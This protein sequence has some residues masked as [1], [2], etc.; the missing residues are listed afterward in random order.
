M[1]VLRICDRQSLSILAAARPAGVVV[2][3]PFDDHDPATLL[4]IIRDMHPD[5]PV[6]FLREAGPASEAVRLLRLGACEY[7]DVVADAEAWRPAAPKRP[8]SADTWRRFLIGESPA[9][10]PVF[11]TIRLLGPRRST[12]LIQG[13][14][15]TGKEMIARALHEASTRANQPLVS[16]N[17]TALPDTLLEAELFG[18]TRGAFTGAMQG[19]VGR[20]EQAQRGTIFLDEIGDLP[21]E[22]QAK[23]LRVL[24]EKELQKLGSGETVKLDVRV[25]AATNAALEHK[26]EEGTFR[27]DLF[28]RLNVV[29]LYIPPLRERWQD[30]PILVEHFIEKICRAENLPAKKIYR[31]TL[32]R[33][34]RYTWPGNVRQLENTVE[35]AIILSAERAVLFP[36]DFSLPKTTQALKLVE[37]TPP[38]VAVPENGMDL[39]M[40]VQKLEKTLIEQALRRTGGNKSQAADILGMK[41]TTLTA[42][43]KVLE[44]AV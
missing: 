37:S 33:L 6:A 43:M 35:R 39:Q 25:V 7:F 29:P 15:G 21:F 42:K 2:A 20:F 10:Q 26:I 23:L 3:L 34:Q 13:E 30:I 24:Q 16:V 4:S 19:R 32:E 14:T 8:E 36:E 41:R 11:D 12:V 27:E 18:H 1:D 9:M 28:Y 5:L 31:E 38:P 44:A 40:T 17:C 22:V